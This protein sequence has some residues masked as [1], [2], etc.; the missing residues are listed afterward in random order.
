MSIKLAANANWY[1][2]LY[3]R[4]AYYISRLVKGTL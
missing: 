2:L 1:L 3:N 4:F